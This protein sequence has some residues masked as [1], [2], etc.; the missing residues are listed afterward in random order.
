M[1]DRWRHRIVSKYQSK[2]DFADYLQ[3][4]IYI[5]TYQSTITYFRI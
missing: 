4:F 1:I 5:R 3:L 2:E